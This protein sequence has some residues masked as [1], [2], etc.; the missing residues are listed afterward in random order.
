M[1][2]HPR[3]NTLRR[4]IAYSTVRERRKEPRKGSE[5]EPETVCSQAVI[6]LRLASVN[7]SGG[8]PVEEWAGE[9]RSVARLRG[10]PSEP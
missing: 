2:H 9:L 3:L 5:I 4:P 7:R 1:D 8:V 6:A 10:D